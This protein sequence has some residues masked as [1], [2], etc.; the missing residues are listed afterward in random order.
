MNPTILSDQTLE[1]VLDKKSED[2]ED[3]EYT[4]V[5]PPMSASTTKKA[6]DLV[7]QVAPAQKGSEESEG[8]DYSVD[9]GFEKGE[10]EEVKLRE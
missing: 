7:Q 3:D 4:E 6:E 1:D 10:G 5:S 9:E 8:D 2:Y